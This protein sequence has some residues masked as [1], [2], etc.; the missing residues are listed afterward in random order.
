MTGWLC[1]FAWICSM[2]DETPL[3]VSMLTFLAMMN[4]LWG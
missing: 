1:F 3:V 2:G 4:E